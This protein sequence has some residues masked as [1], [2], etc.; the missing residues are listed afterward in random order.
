MSR[1]QK[2]RASFRRR[3][4]Y[5]A[6][7]P[8]GI[9]WYKNLSL[10][11]ITCGNQRK[12]HFDNL[13]AKFLNPLYPVI[14]PGCERKYAFK[15]IRRKLSSDNAAPGDTLPE[16]DTLST[17]HPITVQGLVPFPKVLDYDCPIIEHLDLSF[18]SYSYLLTR[19][20]NSSFFSHP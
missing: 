14:A 17:I 4:Q 10:D 11:K 1:A 5:S 19:T 3:W 2:N 12:L 7:K 16:G 20:G 13:Y 8:A 6:N 18:P 15:R 9:L